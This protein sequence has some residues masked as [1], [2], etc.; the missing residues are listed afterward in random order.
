MLIAAVVSALLSAVLVEFRHRT[1]LA[2][3][4]ES[5]R[6]LHARRSQFLLET[7]LMTGPSLFF[8]LAAQL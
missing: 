2:A 6:S 1:F 3:V 5:P 7:W 8:L 4:E